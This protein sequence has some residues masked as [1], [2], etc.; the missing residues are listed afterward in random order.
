MSWPLSRY[1][2]NSGPKRCTANEEKEGA[3]LVAPRNKKV[4]FWLF[5]SGKAQMNTSRP[6]HIPTGIWLDF[7]QNFQKK[8]TLDRPADFYTVH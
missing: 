2:S 4:I 3:A 5:Q 6:S 8:H 1:S 7:V